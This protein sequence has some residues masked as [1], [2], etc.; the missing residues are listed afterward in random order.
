MNR[1]WFESKLRVYVI[2][3]KALSRGRSEEEVVR[4]ALKGGA[5]AIQLRAKSA[6]TEEMLRLGRELRRITREAGALFIVN[7]R[8]DVALAVD[9]DG[10]HVGQEDVP[11]AVARRIVGEKIVGASAGDIREAREAEAQGADYLGV[12]SVFS[13]ASKSDA[14]EPIGLEALNRICRAVRVP[15]MGI[16]GINAENARGVMEAGAKG[17]AVISAVVAADDVERAA[18]QLLEATG[19]PPVRELGEFGL[20]AR[21]REALRRGHA[22]ASA[23]ARSQGA[24][25]PPRRWHD[26][27][28]DVGD[29]AA[30]VAWGG[31]DVS[32]GDLLLAT[33]DML[34][35]RV[36]FDLRFTSAYRLGRKALAVNLSDIAAMGGRPGYALISLG[37]TGDEPLGFIDDLYRGILDLGTCFGVKVV[38]GDIVRSP[39]G[40]AVSVAVFGKGTRPGE[41][42]TRR[43][44]RPGDA[45]LVTGTIGRSALGLKLLEDVELEEKALAAGV[46]PARIAEFK[47]AHLDP[48]PRIAEGQAVAAFHAS[49]A[50]IDISDGLGNEVNHIARESGV[51][52]RV[53]KDLLPFEEDYLE[54]CRIGEIAPV[55]LALFGG[56]DYEL[57]FTVRKNE[58]DQLISSVESS[59]GTRCHVIGEVLPPGSGVWLVSGAGEAENL[60]ASAYDHFRSGQA[61]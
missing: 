40:L 1:R 32:D 18:R 45:I 3:D 17:V 11:V 7:D 41:V 30:C 60:E 19:G 5:T 20:I 9:A 56:E 26:V 2:T 37:L 47:G 50:M 27:V 34:V 35:E 28:V 15:V 53:L 8:P 29:D 61:R 24:A 39:C 4:A 6:S 21:L 33:A 22:A 59:T 10:V 38:G 31:P 57:V 13:T 48:F 49:G 58:V 42:K 44:A 12:G 46:S 14:G 16:G 51:G 52:A 25:L 36:H 55:P 54:I 43:G 23:G